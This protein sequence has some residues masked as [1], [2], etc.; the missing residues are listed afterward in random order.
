M[1]LV[2][3]KEFTVGELA[4]QL[5][6]RAANSR[7]ELLRRY[8]PG[9]VRRLGSSAA[10]A[11]EMVEK[12]IRQDAENAVAKKGNATFAVIPDNHPLGSATQV[13]GVAS[14]LKGLEVSIQRFPIAPRLAERLPA[15]LISKHAELGTT[16]VTGWVSSDQADLL[17]S[18]YID[19]MGQLPKRETAWTIEPV[20]SAAAAHGAIILAGM[21]AIGSPQRYDVGEDGNVVP[22]VSQAYMS[23]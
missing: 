11:T 9:T 1:T 20:R 22:P 10:I 7:D 12:A 13:I 17:G 4:P 23:L 5:H 6:E 3:F 21:T 16:N 19:L 18:V 15:H 14:M 8:S 2:R